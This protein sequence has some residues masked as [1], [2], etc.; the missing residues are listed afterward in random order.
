MAPEAA[1]DQA[2]R[3]VEEIFTKYPIRQS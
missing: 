2:F 3:R 1:I